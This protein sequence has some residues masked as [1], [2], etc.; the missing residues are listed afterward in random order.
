[1][2]LGIFAKT[3]QRST[4]EETLDAVVAHGLRCI[5]FNYACA[6]L[7]SLPQQLDTADVKRIAGAI[8]QR[9]LEVAAVSGTF[10]IIHPDAA[11]R[12]AGFKALNVIAANCAALGTKVVTLCTGTFDP[13]DMWREHPE[14]NLPP[15]WKQMLAGIERA[16]EI[17]ETHDVFLGIEP[18]MA[19]VIN[20]AEK[21][22]RL[23]DS[24]KNPRLK[25]VMDAANLLSPEN[26]GD[27]PA[28]LKNAFDLLGDDIAIAHAKDIKRSGQF[29]AAGKGDVDWDLYLTLLNNARFSGAL[30]LH[31][32][33]EFE[34]TSSVELL[35]GK[36][37]AIHA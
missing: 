17:A 3:F 24:L 29:A 35:A 23:L 2:R 14:N 8:Q 26:F 37:K 12:D 30:I 34:V 7:P 19:N 6:G 5:Q 10:N 4:I 16:L 1:M 31:G 33:A 21:A 15:A 36:L 9:G 32:L 18:E 13:N 20:S 28:V 27:A 25:I 22:R 11:Q